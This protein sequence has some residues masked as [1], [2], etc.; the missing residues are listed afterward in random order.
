MFSYMSNRKPLEA[1][2]PNK[3]KR[4]GKVGLSCLKTLRSRRFLARSR[5]ATTLASLKSELRG[6]ELSTAASD[7]ERERVF[8]Q[9]SPTFPD[10][11]TYRGVSPQ[12]VRRKKSPCHPIPQLPERKS[13][14]T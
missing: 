1:K 12:I 11:T 9:D 8:E 13:T 6:W 14:T 7:A 4:F 5:A 10:S 3:R 2:L